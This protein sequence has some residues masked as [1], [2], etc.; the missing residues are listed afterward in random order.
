MSF[1]HETEIRGLPCRKPSGTTIFLA[2]PGTGLISGK[3]IFIASHGPLTEAQFA[4]AK[5]HHRLDGPK[6]YKRTFAWEFRN[7][8]YLDKPVAFE[9]KKGVQTFQVF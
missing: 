7:P 8:M 4:A 3:V 5:E 1:R 2:R 9:Y 6:R